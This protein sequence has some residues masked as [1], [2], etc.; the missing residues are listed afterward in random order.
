MASSSYG[1][2]IR[3]LR[4]A[5][6]ELHQLLTVLVANCD[7]VCNDLED[8]VAP[9]DS[10]LSVGGEA[11]QTFRRDVHAATTRFVAAMQASRAESFRVLVRDG[12]FSVSALARSTA[13]SAQM[14][15]RLLRV[16]EDI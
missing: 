2:R 16:A 3:D 1:A 12:G 11:G 13:L 9:L 10:I 6:A 14:I 5:G 15:R 7:Q 8:G 4:D